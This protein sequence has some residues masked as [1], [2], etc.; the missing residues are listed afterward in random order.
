MGDEGAPSFIA[1]CF[2]P[3]VREEQVEAAAARVQ[4]GVDDL[5]RRG[6]PITFVG[7]ILVPDD[8]TVFY[9][10]ERASAETVREACEQASIPVGRV[11]RSVPRL[12]SGVV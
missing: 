5:S 9:L 10:F 1:E 4:R 12:A 2:W 6:R 3:D 11:V 7:T 8:E